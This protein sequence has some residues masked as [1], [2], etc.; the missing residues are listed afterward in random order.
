[1]FS[2]VFDPA[3]HLVYSARSDAVQTV[4]VEGKVLM[5]RRRV[6]TLDVEPIRR[7][8]RLFGKRIRAALPEN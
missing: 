2:P 7:R 8:A 6:K 5:E 1:M 4:M 3:S